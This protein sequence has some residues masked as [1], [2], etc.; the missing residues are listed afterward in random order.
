MS[1][2]QFYFKAKGSKKWIYC[3]GM[4]V[5]PLTTMVCYWKKDKLT[6]KQIEHIRDV[7]KGDK[8]QIKYCKESK[9]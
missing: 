6:G 3:H 8:I 5:R 2:I 7:R 4:W 9:D 1:N